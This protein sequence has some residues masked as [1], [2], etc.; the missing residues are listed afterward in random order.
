MSQQ[1]EAKITTGQIQVREVTSWQVTWT[2]EAPGALGT[3]TVQLI[4]DD[5][6]DEYIIRPTADDVD[7]LQEVFDD[8][9]KVFF[10]LERK[11]LMFGV[12]SVG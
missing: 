9:E 2:E 1:G 4:L 7:V 12:R 10:D 5:G 3:W 6:A 8:A 11:V